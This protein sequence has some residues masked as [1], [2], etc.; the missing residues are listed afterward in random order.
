[1][2]NCLCGKRQRLSPPSP[3]EVRQHMGGERDSQLTTYEVDPSITN[4]EER[5]EIL[6]K[7]G[8]TIRSTFGM[9]GPSKINHEENQKWRRYVSLNGGEVA[10]EAR[11]KELRIIHPKQDTTP[12]SQAS[13]KTMNARRL[14][15]TTPPYSPCADY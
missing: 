9:V 12:A 1:M 10:S 5:R 8:Y 4:I 14:T 11:L 13:D 7:Q 3:I 6:R 15:L 2:L